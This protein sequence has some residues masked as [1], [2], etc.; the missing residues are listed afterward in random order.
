MSFCTYSFICTIFCTY[1]FIST[2]NIL[3][4][5]FHM[6]IF[7]TYS[8]CTYRYVSRVKWS[9]PGKGVAVSPTPQCSSLWKGSLLIALE[10]SPQLYFYFMSPL[11]IF[12]I[13]FTSLEII[14]L[15]NQ[16]IIPLTLDTIGKISL[17]ALNVSSTP[18]RFPCAFKFPNSFQSPSTFS[19]GLH[20]LLDVVYRRPRCMWKCIQFWF[21]IILLNRNIVFWQF[22]LSTGDVRFLL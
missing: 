14:F 17:S 18:N 8:I 5:L 16:P 13:T 7:C 3:Y 12:K 22:H 2:I 1:S 10:Y 4:V 20:L 15:T 11:C 9:N 21:S 19:N 6:Q